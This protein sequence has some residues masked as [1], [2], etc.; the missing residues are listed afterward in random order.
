MPAP[1]QRPRNR[2][3]A[4]YYHASRARGDE[5]VA[6]HAKRLFP[7]QVVQ[8]LLAIVDARYDDAVAQGE[9][10]EV[11]ARLAD[12]AIDLND[13]LRDGEY[14]AF[15]TAEGWSGLGAAL[16]RADEGIK[17]LGEL[18]SDCEEIHVVMAAAAKRR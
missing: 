3:D 13:A 15:R 4:A 2:R 12:A 18:I 5:D 14:E 7:A 8:D 6:A 17:T 11:L 1:R 16:R 9:S 10:P